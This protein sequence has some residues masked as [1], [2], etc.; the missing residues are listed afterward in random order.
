ML[1]IQI[2]AADATRKWQRCIDN[3][4]LLF[5]CFLDPQQQFSLTHDQI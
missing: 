4:K 3:E 2:S 1:F 5:K